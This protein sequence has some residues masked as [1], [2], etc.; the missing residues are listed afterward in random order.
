MTTTGALQSLPFSSE[1]AD[2]LA[3]PGA[4]AMRVAEEVFALADLVKTDARLRRA[5]TDPS[6][7]AEDKAALARSLFGAHMSAPALSIV[8]ALVRA[9]W[10]KPEKLHD[11]AEVLGIL[12]VLTD[13]LRSGALE[14]VDDELFEARR[15][16]ASERDLR[17]TLSDMSTGTAHERADLAT[18]IFSDRLS[19]WSMRLLRRAVGRSRH[20]RLLHNLRRFAEW[21]A[22]LQDRLLVTVESAVDMT[23]EQVARLRSLLERRFEREITLSISIDPG[24]VGGFRLRADTTAIDA[25]LAARI[26]DMK[27]A[28]AG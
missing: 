13:A 23:P 18:R 24:L 5:L 28:L 8:D 15:L 21:A 27:R 22:T 12:A 17:L 20:G 4:D 11:A 7:S 16:L 25:S 1:L 2:A 9:H 3:L 6:R 10:T 14:R 26:T 19:R